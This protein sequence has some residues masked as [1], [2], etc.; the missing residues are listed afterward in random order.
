[1][2]HAVIA[3]AHLPRATDRLC[4]AIGQ[5]VYHRLILRRHR[6]QQPLA[7]RREADDGSDPHRS[8]TLV[9]Q[10]ICFDRCRP[11]IASINVGDWPAQR[12]RCHVAVE[13]MREDRLWQRRAGD[14]DA[15]IVRRVAAIGKQQR[16]AGITPQL[17]NHRGDSMAHIISDGATA[18][19]KSAKGGNRTIHRPVDHPAGHFRDAW[20]AGIQLNIGQILCA[21]AIAPQCLL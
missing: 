17:V 1:M 14:D 12:L 4:L 6:C 3:P 9:E 8:V 19:G 2:Q 13:I 7:L 10:G 21:K 20:K 15:V 5:E 11:F 16:S 18:E